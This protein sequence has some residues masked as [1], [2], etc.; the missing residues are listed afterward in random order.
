MLSKNEKKWKQYVQ[1]QVDD[2]HKLSREI[3]GDFVLVNIIQQ[4]FP[5]D[6]ALPLKELSMQELWWNGPKFLEKTADDW[7]N[8]PTTY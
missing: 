2:I 7:P 1:H 4:I 5:H 3:V 8:L 6:R